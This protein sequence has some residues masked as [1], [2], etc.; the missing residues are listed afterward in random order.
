MTWKVA[1]IVDVEK[2]F[3]SKPINV[4]DRFDWRA[5]NPF[6]A[7][8]IINYYHLQGVAIKLTCNF[9]FF[10]CQTLNIIKFNNI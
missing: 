9:L 6:Q 2:N 5:K 3:L 1:L 7:D 10:F 8:K 4:S